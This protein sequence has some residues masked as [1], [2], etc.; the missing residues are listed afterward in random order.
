MTYEPD[1][2]DYV[3]PCGRAFNTR[4]S[5]HIELYGKGYKIGLACPACGQMVL[6][7]SDETPTGKKD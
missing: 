2:P 4:W 6:D 3:C 7:F 1:Y 5:E